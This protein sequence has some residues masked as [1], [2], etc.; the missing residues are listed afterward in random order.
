MISTQFTVPVSQLE[1]YITK[2]ITLDY[3]VVPLSKKE[4]E[5]LALYPIETSY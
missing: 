2:R 5:F 4:E 3:Q 1:S